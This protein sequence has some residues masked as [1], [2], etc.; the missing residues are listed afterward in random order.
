MGYGYSQ[1]LV[2]A[3]KAADAK[4]LG[5][6]LGRVCIARGISVSRV[7][8]VFGVSR[9]SVYSWFKGVSHPHPLLATRIKKY[10]DTKT[11]KK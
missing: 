11:E 9:M 5:V 4:N 2:L 3:N 1:N 6:A 7:A 8:E 10:I